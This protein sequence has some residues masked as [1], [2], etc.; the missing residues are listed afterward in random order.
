MGYLV[1]DRPT[2]FTGI[3]PLP[4]W[5]ISRRTENARSLRAARRPRRRASSCFGRFARL[6]R[7]RS[8]RE[9][10]EREIPLWWLPAWLHAAACLQPGTVKDTFINRLTSMRT[11]NRSLLAFSPPSFFFFHGYENFSPLRFFACLPACLCAFVLWEIFLLFSIFWDSS[12]PFFRGEGVCMFK[13]LLCIC[14][15]ER[16]IFVVREILYLFLD[17]FSSLKFQLIKIG[18]KESIVLSNSSIP[19]FR[20][21]SVGL[22]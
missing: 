6:S 18:L 12:L 9:E 13:D 1:S 17:G 7:A 5:L 11:G 4:G 22:E 16:L 20:S 2:E 21:V 8:P 19:S 14:L 10:R 3:G 15:F